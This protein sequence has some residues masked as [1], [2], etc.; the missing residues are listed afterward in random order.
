MIRDY[1][2]IKEVPI[3]LF[4]FPYFCIFPPLSI[5]ILSIEDNVQLECGKRGMYIFK[6]MILM[7]HIVY[8]FSF[9][10]SRV[11]VLFPF[12][13]NFFLSFQVLVS[14]K[15]ELKNRYSDFNE[16]HCEKVFE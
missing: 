7:L 3:P 8:S 1:I 10:I 4:F 14:V 11:L 12:F 9:L 16:P 5:M 2:Y 15:M 13:A 6:I